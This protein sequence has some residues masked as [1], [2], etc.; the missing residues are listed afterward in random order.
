MEKPQKVFIS[1]YRPIL[2]SEGSKVRSVYLAAH[3][4]EIRIKHLQVTQYTSIAK[5]MENC[6]NLIYHLHNTL[7]ESSTGQNRTVRPF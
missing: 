5:A 1:K 4:M 6:Y 7:V 3:D 2:T